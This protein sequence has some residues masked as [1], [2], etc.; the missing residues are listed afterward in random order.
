MSVAL[1]QLKQM[2]IL[3]LGN[4][5]SKE[6][7]LLRIQCRKQLFYILICFK[8]WIEI[9][10][11][12][13]QNSLLGVGQILFKTLVWFVKI[14]HQMATQVLHLLFAQQAEIWVYYKIQEK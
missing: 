11:F 6:T 1:T 10:Q 9:K 4:Y 12:E 7:F 3:K 5:Y 8:Q 2:S 13:K 14:F